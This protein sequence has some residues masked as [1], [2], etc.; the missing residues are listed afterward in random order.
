[1][2]VPATP[3][4]K[5]LAVG[6]TLDASE[7]PAIALFLA[8][9]AARN[10]QL[11]NSVMDEHLEKFPE[12][13]REEQDELARIWCDAIGRSYNSDSLRE[14]VKPGALGGMWNWAIELQY[15]LLH[16]EWHVLHTSRQKPFVTS[17]WPVFAQWDPY[18]DVRL[19]SFPVSSEY[20]LIIVGRGQFN[21]A[22]NTA[23]YV[24]A[25]NRQTINKAVQFVVSCKNA[26][27]ADEHLIKRC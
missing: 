11:M 23:D 26:F 19:V 27:P 13:N 3:A 4:L 9:T 20:A 25:M 12:G 15:R 8:L 24:Y 1:V 21:E 10:P 16:W 7:R 14:F 17:D 18:Q 5:K 2:E 22:Y 6:E